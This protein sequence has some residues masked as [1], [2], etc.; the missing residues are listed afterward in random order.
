MCFR[1]YET[2]R[3]ADGGTI[4]REPLVEDFGYCRVLADED[5]DRGARI[6]RRLVPLFPHSFPPRSQDRDGVMSILKDHLRLGA[7]F[8]SDTFSRSQLRQNPL[9]DVEVAGYLCARGVS[10]RQLWNLDQ[11]SFDSVY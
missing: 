9:P 8:L 5:E 2:L 4:V 11:P 7:A 6:S 10:H 1:F 3:N